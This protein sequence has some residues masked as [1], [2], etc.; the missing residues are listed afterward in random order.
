MKMRHIVLARIDDRLIHGQI[1]T[2]W[3]KSTNANTILIVDDK[4]SDDSF[5]QRLLRAAAPP[6]IKV[7]IMNLPAAALWLAEDDS[8]DQR[9]ILLS[10][11]PQVMEELIK[12]GIPLKSVNLGGMGAKAGRSKLNK[13]ISASPEEVD[14]LRRMLENEVEIFY[15]LVPVERPV[16][17][18]NILKGEST[19]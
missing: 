1:V 7:E 18:I 5:T 11:T 16:N 9:I 15:Q 14:C 19:K 12:N 17:M 4:L 2:S 13:N 3:C 8:K 6:D 10:K